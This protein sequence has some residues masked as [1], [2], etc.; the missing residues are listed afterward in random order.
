MMERFNAGFTRVVGPRV[1]VAPDLRGL[2]NGAL[3]ATDLISTNILAPGCSESLIQRVFR[4]M[5][6]R[7]GTFDGH[8]DCSSRAVGH[9]TTSSTA[10]ES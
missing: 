4:N 8:I 5:R 9:S 2:L 10:P 3:T 7:R 6:E 1:F